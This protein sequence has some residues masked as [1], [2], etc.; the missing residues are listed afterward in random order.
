M[1]KPLLSWRLIEAR[2][3]GLRF[4]LQLKDLFP[5]QGRGGAPVKERGHRTG[6]RQDNSGRRYAGS[7]EHQRPPNGKRSRK[8]PRKQDAVRL[9]VRSLH[10]PP[11]I[12]TKE[13]RL[14][15]SN[16][17][18]FLLHVRPPP[19]FTPPTTT[20]H[21]ATLL[22]LLLQILKGLEMESRM[23]IRFLDVDTSTMRCGKSSS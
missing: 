5:L 14:S 13:S 18:D 21:S 23:H 16:R 10:R 11:T 17:F 22:S 3:A 2:T 8:R 15:I 9:T 4:H 1:F 12:S 19:L 20:T 7:G 6:S